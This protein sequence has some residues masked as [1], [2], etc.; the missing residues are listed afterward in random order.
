MREPVELAILSGVAVVAVASAVVIVLRRRKNP[1]ERERLRR[2]AVNQ[3]GRMGDAM[4]TEASDGIVYYSYSIRGVEYA[5]S[6]DISML[7]DRIDVDLETLVGPVTLKF[8]PRN[9][10]NSIVLCEEWSGI[11]NQQSTLFKKGA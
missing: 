8:M 1:Q 6:Q 5:A 4:I 3:Y 2:L 7:R 11:R 10:F 9:P